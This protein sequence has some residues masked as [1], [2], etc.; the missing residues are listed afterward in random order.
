MPDISI[1]DA[2]EEDAAAIADIYNH[3]VLNTV[4]TFDMEPKS[5]RDRVDWIHEHGPLHPVIV[6]EQARRV[7]GWASLSPFSTRPAWSR[8][9]ELGLYLAPDERARGIGTMLMRAVLDRARSAGHHVVIGQIVSDNEP[10]IRLGERMGFCEVGR[11][12]E[13]GHKFDRTLDV[14]IQQLIL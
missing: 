13:V 1:R 9:V 14:V 4:V 12:L 10:S 2:R 8:T 6:A 3:Y 5:V 11:M 7:V